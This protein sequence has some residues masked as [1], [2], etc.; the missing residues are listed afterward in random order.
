MVVLTPIVE[1]HRILIPELL[2]NVLSSLEANRDLYSTSLVCSSWSDL[3][4]D[5]LWR[6]MESVLPLLKALAPMAESAELE[7]VS[8]YAG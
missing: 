2:T 8:P 7:W 4:L 5:V 6:T 1:L 3:S